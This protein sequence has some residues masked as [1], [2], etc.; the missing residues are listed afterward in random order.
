MSKQNW[1]IGLTVVLIILACF[2]FW[3]TLKLWTMS[4]AEQAEM[5][6]NDP[7]GL[8]TLQQKA[9]RLGLDLQG[10]IHVVLRVKLEEIDPAGHDDAVERAIQI[11]RNRVDGLGVAEPVIQK[12]GND[13]I[14]V[15]LPGYTDADRAEELIGHQQQIEFISHN[16]HDS[17]YGQ[18]IMESS[19]SR[20]YTR[21]E[22]KTD[23]NIK[24]DSNQ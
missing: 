8:L 13:R 20:S 12:Q 19:N 7:G 4:E 23:P 15:D 9:I 18:N 1:R 21:T 16:H 2:A 17:Q 24:N 22:I 3:N 14:I 11:I 10:G 6:E 5:Q